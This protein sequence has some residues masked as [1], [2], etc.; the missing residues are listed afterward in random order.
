MALPRGPLAALDSSGLAASKTPSSSGKV[1]TASQPGA[2]TITPRT[3]RV[4]RG[5]AGP[6]TPVSDSGS[7]FLTS[8][9]GDGLS[10][11]AES[12]GGAMP[13]S[14]GRAPDSPVPS[15]LR[16]VRTRTRAAPRRPGGQPG[17]PL[18]RT[19]CPRPLSSERS[20]QTRTGRRDAHP[21]GAGIGAAVPV[22]G[23]SHGEP[24]GP[25]PR[26]LPSSVSSIK[27]HTRRAG[28]EVRDC[29]EQAAGLLRTRPHHG[30][31]PRAAQA[32]SGLGGRP[33]LTPVCIYAAQREAQD[34]KGK[35]D[36]LQSSQGG[37]STAVGPRG[38]L[39]AW[40]EAQSLLSSPWVWG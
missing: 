10:P 15:P 14:P 27:H 22:R 23:G 9:R 1:I 31:S 32:S 13:R 24:H 12:Q 30:P 38:F 33:F 6:P 5:C 3:C 39:R 8:D 21:F 20:R 11:E 35:K 4:P 2:P 40:R 36:R 25:G 26:L 37:A 19:C 18:L 29:G 16:P 34:R 7:A 28:G 17:Q